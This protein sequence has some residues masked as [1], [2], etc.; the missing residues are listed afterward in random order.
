MADCLADLLKRTRSLKAQRAA[1]YLSLSS[2]IENKINDSISLYE[3]LDIS[4]YAPFRAES[5][6]GF[7]IL[8]LS[9]TPI[10]SFP[11]PVKPAITRSLLTCEPSDLSD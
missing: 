3:F 1:N 2:E 11:K 7:F 9:L 10:A 8:H 5:C 4:L 6:I